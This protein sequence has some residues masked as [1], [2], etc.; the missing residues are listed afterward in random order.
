M[1]YFA[2]MLAGGAGALLRYLLGRVAVNFGL[3]A[4]PFGTLIANLLGSFLIGYLSWMLVQ[5]WQASSDV[6]LIVLTGFL[7]GFT[8]FSAFSLETI[9]MLEQGAGLRA[10]IYVFLTVGLCLAMCMFGLLVARHT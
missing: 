3:S 8:T 5:R 4:L 10:M 9:T 1:F 2:L 6:Q 7:G